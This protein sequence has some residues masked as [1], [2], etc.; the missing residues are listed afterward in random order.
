LLLLLLWEAELSW[1]QPPPR[2]RL[3]VTHRLLALA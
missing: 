1:D 2:D 3:P